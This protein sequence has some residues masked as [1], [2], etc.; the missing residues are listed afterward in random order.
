MKILMVLIVGLVLFKTIKPAKTPVFC[1]SF[2]NLDE[3]END[4][5]SDN[6]EWCGS[7]IECAKFKNCKP[8]TTGGHGYCTK[9]GE[10]LCN[11]GYVFYNNTCVENTEI[12][13][14]AFRVI[15]R[16]VSSAKGMLGKK[17]CGLTDT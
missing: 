17:I 13:N 8:C 4:F 12:K 2:M 9:E 16:I 6:N 14:N 7:Q 3:V 11:E 15:E 1:P 10:M 5:E